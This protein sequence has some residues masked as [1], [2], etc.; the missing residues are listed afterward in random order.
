M[1]PDPFAAPH[2]RDFLI[3]WLGSTV[4]A[5][6]DG[7]RRPRLPSSVA[8]AS[9]D[10]TRRHR[11]PPRRRRRPGR[12]LA[13]A[14]S[15]PSS[16]PSSSPTCWI[17]GA[18]GSQRQGRQRHR[19]P[20]GGRRRSRNCSPS[21]RSA[22]QV[23]GAVR[24]GLVVIESQHPGAP[25]PRISAPGSSSTPRATSSP[26]STSSRAGPPSRSPSPTAPPRPRPSSRPTPTT[27]SPC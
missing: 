8:T 15:W 22:A 2:A 25:A 21:R 12:S 18:P 17:S 19:R 4:A 1:R 9:T 14:S 7:G 5:M 24:A 20:E 11:R 23:Y 13:P 27:T 6:R 10:P 16:P 3:E 26:R